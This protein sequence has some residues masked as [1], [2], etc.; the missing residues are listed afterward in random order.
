VAIE[1]AS[2]DR[3]E[4]AGGFMT[5]AEFL[6]NGWTSGVVTGAVVAY[7]EMR[8]ETFKSHFLLAVL[9][10]IGVGVLAGII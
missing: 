7:V 10:A 2:H 9:A 1:Q 8:V 5:A 4:R 6:R 3:G